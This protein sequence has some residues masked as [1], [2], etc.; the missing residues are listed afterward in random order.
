MK[1]RIILIVLVVVLL[2][3]CLTQPRPTINLSSAKETVIT[4]D[5]L[6]LIILKEWNKANQQINS[7]PIDA[8]NVA[9]R[10]DKD[11]F[12]VPLRDC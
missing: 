10:I 6:S 11:T 3:G 8:C 5:P 4:I 2:C 1:H 12:Q 7:F 9:V